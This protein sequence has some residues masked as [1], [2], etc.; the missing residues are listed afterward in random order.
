MPNSMNTRNGKKSQVNNVANF[1][2]KNPDYSNEYE[3][4]IHQKTN[5]NFLEPYNGQYSIDPR[6]LDSC[7]LNKN[8]TQQ[9]SDIRNISIESQ[10]MH[11][12]ATHIPGQRRILET[13]TNRFNLLPFDPQDHR[14]IVWKDNMPRGGYSTRSDRVND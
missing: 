9:N 2:T 3:Y 6:I 12:E 4:G 10:L 13:E 14:H 8:Q 5:G 1:I 7:G 11:R